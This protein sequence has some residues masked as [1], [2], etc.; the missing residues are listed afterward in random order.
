MVDI[1]TIGIGFDTA[2]LVKGQRALKD[3][4]QAANKTA[5]AA[6]K[7]GSSGSRG[8]KEYSNAAAMAERQT[9]VLADTT[10]TFS[11]IMGTAFAGLGIGQVIG[12]TDQYTKFTAQLKLATSG[13]TEYANALADVRRISKDAQADISATGV[14]YARIANGTRELGVSQQKVADITEVVNLSLKVSGATSAESA[15]AMLQLSQ[16]FASGTLRG[17]EFNAVNEAAPRLMKALAD[18]IG[19]P[20][21]ALKEMATNG[22]I[23][24][25]I[26]SRVL[27]K[28]LGDL[29]KEAESVQTISG[30]YTVLKNNV[31]EF[32]GVQAQA[33]GTVSALTSGIG[34]LA[35]NV[36]LVAAAAVGFGS[37]KFAE[38]LLR[39]GEKTQ[40]NIAKTMEY[41]AAQQAQ[42][43]SSIA[44]AQAE[45]ARS[46]AMLVQGAATRT[47]IIL[48]REE[49]LAKL[50]LARSDISAAQASM[51]AATA[52]GAQSFALRVLKDATNEL[53]VAE[54]RRAALVTELAVLGQQQTR[55][56]AQIT[57]A[58]AA[59]AA[60][61]TAL[62]TAA[63][64]S[65]GIMSRAL[66]LLGGPIGIISTLL[67]IGVTAWMAWGSASESQEKRATDSVEKSTGEI[68][69]DLDRQIAKLKE[70]NA[71]SASGLTGI[72]QSDSAV[73]TRM[74]KLRAQMAAAQEGSGEF[75]G[76]AIEARTDILQKLGMQYGE[77][78]AK[79]QQVNEEQA[80]LDAG[81][82]A[83]SDLIEV[84]QRLLGV[85]KQYLEDLSKLETARAKGA[86]GEQEYIALVSQLAT[87]TYK[88]SRAGKEEVTEYEKLIKSI[89]EKTAI[90]MLDL[91]TQGKLTDGQKLAVKI[92]DDLR[93]GTLALTA[94]EKK[95]LSGKLES[96]LA[97]ENANKERK[98]ETDAVKELAD[99]YDRL[100]G[101][102]DKI[103]EQVA[104]QEEY[105]DRIGLSKTMVAALDAA[106]LEEQATSKD[107]IATMMDEIDWSGRLGDTYRQQAEELRK[108]AGAKRQGAGKEAL[109]EQ[110]KK[111]ADESQKVWDNFSQNVQRNL[112]DTLFNV[113]QGKF[114]G[115]GASFRAMLQRM[116]AD[117]MAAN[118]SKALFTGGDSGKGWVGAALS[119]LGGFGSSGGSGPSSTVGG[120]DW[121]SGFDVG[122]GRA[123]GGGVSPFSIQEVNEL[124]PELLSSGGK[125]YLMMGS[126]GGNVTPN[127]KIGGKQIQVMYAPVIQIDSRTDRAEVQMLVQRAVQ[128]GN[129]EL[130]DKLQRTGAL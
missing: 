65:L 11:R 112:G 95:N 72:G 30:A 55:I 31:L 39:I 100:T 113:M 74:G 22:Q 125:D 79:V 21:G 64:A 99:L 124:G 1:E 44:V 114:D 123:G 108:L 76:L 97:A 77:L 117:A 94:S 17:E 2:G 7:V 38:M 9:K 122:V 70:R 103:R 10:A 24:S 5:D 63:G 116:L 12:L 19:V 49:T 111:I 86:I 89:S 46:E 120:V 66:G 67:G 4:E 36:N 71:L 109:V 78:Y 92:M 104:A 91:E 27:P 81:G 8:F 98:K 20:V 90:E 96:Y 87:Q 34:L 32:V 37:A 41:I 6:D 40:E 62:G 101:D 51:A 126:Q 88:K 52:A 48:T 35:N 106:K 25:E 16:S 57:A 58:T 50:A 56:S 23:T 14:L 102:R 83:A 107:S 18:G 75:A 130:V 15:S 53:A 105:N 119:L 68:V 129:A 84:R 115:I 45:I 59:Q 121:T 43:T 73:A 3:T 82:K 128:Q 28:A 61:Q 42:R 29:R 60:A 93:T 85:N 118:L 110:Q 54:A 127:N 80:K 33:N 47:A 26:M 13:G 69:S